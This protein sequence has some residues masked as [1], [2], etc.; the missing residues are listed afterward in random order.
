[1]NPSHKTTKMKT[2]HP[3]V[4]F[5]KIR[6]AEKL[7]DRRIGAFTLVELLT[8]IAI[9]SILAGLVVTGVSKFKSAARVVTSTNRMRSIGTAYFLYVAENRQKLVMNADPNTPTVTASDYTIQEAV[10]PY[11]SLSSVGNLRFADSV[12]W[13]AHAELNGLR[14]QGGAENQLYYP[15]PR[16]YP[17]G[18]PRNKIRGF[19]FNYTIRAPDASGGYSHMSQIKV[20]AKMALILSRRNDTGASIWNVW[21]DD[22]EY[23]ATNPKSIGAKRV[24]FYFDGHVGTEQITEANYNAS[25]YF[26]K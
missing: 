11:L 2:N 3:S 24:I 19:N 17:G 18:P 10:A 8:V 4:L 20:P 21:A 25:A 13:D 5:R 16:I 1:M 9:I 12:W 6:S 14:T 23:S 15:D 7:H 26:L 22:K